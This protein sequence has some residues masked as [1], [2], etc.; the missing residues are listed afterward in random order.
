[1]SSGQRV[2]AWLG[3]ALTLPA[4]FDSGTEELP[5]SLADYDGASCKLLPRFQMRANH[6]ST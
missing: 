2:A 4:M 3:L 1:M 6:G 5:S